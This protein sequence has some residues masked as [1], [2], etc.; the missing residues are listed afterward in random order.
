MNIKQQI[1]KLKQQMK[2]HEIADDGYYISR[3][4]QEDLHTL[5][6]LENLANTPAKPSKKP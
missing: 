3:Q 2:W 5:Y 4:Y 1:S 6:Q